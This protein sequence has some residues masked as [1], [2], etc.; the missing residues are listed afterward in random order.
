MYV[1]VV[2]QVKLILLHNFFLLTL[3][4]TC[5]LSSFIRPMPLSICFLGVLNRFLSNFSKFMCC[6]HD[7]KYSLNNYLFYTLLNK[8]ENIDLISK[9]NAILTIDFHSLVYWQHLPFIHFF[10]PTKTISMCIIK[11]RQVR[12]VTVPGLLIFY[13]RKTSLHDPSI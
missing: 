12:F 5:F 9:E 8:I 11:S 3:R 6:K 13:L 2:K 4:L 1:C 10:P 7:C